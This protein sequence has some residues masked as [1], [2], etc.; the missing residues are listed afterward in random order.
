[1]GFGFAAFVF[2]CKPLFAG[3]VE[4]QPTESGVK[5]LE[6]NVNRNAGLLRESVQHGGKDGAFHIREKRNG[7]LRK[8]QFRIVQKLHRIGT[9][10]HAKPFAMRTPTQRRVERKMMRRQRAETSPAL[11]AR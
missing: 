2:D 11:V 7:P 6:R 4:N 1:M 5:L 10:L 3:S 9:A 8:R